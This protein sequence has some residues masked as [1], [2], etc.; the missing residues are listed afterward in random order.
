MDEW[1]NEWVGW[2]M[3]ELWIAERGKVVAVGRAGRK[4]ETEIRRQEILRGRKDEKE[5][6]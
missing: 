4:G 1:M 6:I 2:L 3:V 5:R